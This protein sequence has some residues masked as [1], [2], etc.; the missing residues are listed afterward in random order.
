MSIHQ[1]ILLV[2]MFAV[3]MS[4]PSALAGEDENRYGGVVPNGEPCKVNGDCENGFCKTI[5]MEIPGLEERQTLTFKI[6]ECNFFLLINFTRSINIL[7]QII[8]L[9]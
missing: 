4:I 9:F 3:V 8:S 5:V 6:C 1:C 7:A 2:A